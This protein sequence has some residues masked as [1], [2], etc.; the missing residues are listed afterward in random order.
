MTETGA[1]SADAARVRQAIAL[2]AVTLDATRLRP[3]SRPSDRLTL[4]RRALVGADVV[5]LSLAY[6]AAALVDGDLARRSSAALF[7]LSIPL[8]VLAALGFGLYRHDDRPEHSTVDE[9]GRAVQLL[10][11]GAWCALLVVWAASGRTITTGA[12]VFWA[13]SILLVPASRAV[14]RAVVHRRRSYVQRT[15]IVGAGDVGQLVARKLVQHPEW[16]LR[17][18]GFLDARPRPLRCEVEDVPVLGEPGE[19]VEVVRANHADRVIVAFSDDPPEELADAV[20]SLRGLG[21]QVDLVPRLF[22]AIGPVDEVH[23]VEGLPLV[24]AAPSRR[25]SSARFAKRA[26][27]VVLGSLLLALTLPFFAWVAWRI[28][29]DSEGPV[30]FRQVRL[31]E[32]QR[33]FTVLKFRTMAADT[34]DTPHREYVR[35]IMSPGA[36]PNG[37]GLYKLDRREAVTPFGAWLRRTSLDELPQLINV[38]RGEMS[39]VGPRPCLSYETELFEPRHFDRFLVPAGM[40]GLWQVEAR[41]LATLKEALDLDAA[42]ARSWSLR[43]DLWV[44]ARTPLA[45]LRGGTTT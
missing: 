3:G 18:V 21:T 5:A 1:T 27:D 29:R 2:P 16:G 32:G 22:D 26:I 44:L 20:H 11:G 17:V 4:V 33:P 28:K 38:V 31:G 35:H 14:A 8:W 15:V 9:L 41:A 23:H 12:A 7:A 39:L 19:L 43:L 40:T 30:F 6:T 34:D 36:A 25:S 45:L 10:T 37:N 42:Y 13:T 24:S